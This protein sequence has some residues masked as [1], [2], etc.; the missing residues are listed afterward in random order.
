MEINIDGNT[1]RFNIPSNYMSKI[2]ELNKK[3]KDKNEIK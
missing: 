3:Q 1:Y 2:N